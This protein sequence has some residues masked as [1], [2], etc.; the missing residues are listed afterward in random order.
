MTAETWSTETYAPREKETAGGSFQN[1]I[2]DRL[3]QLAQTISR[4]SAATEP[5]SEVA[6]YGQQ[7]SEM[8]EESADYLKQLDLRQVEAS[9]RNYVKRNPGRS[10]L[11]AG[12]AGLVIGTIL[13]RR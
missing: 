4:K 2:A 3:Q 9:A 8:L 10:L 7:A 12:A 13:R 6:Y 5:D 11:I 1:M